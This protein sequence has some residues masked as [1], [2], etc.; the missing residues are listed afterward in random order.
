MAEKRKCLKI[1]PEGQ[2]HESLPIL[3]RFFPV[4]GNSQKPRLLLE[5][6]L[7]QRNS[8]TTQKKVKKH[9]KNLWEEFFHV[10]KNFLRIAL[11]ASF[12][13]LIQPAFSTD[14]HFEGPPSCIPMVNCIAP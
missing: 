13:L 8:G 4:F 11:L 6:D 7:L 2:P 1:R 14:T 5:I 12:A 9:T 10:K 3:E